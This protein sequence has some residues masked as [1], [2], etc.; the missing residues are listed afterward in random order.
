MKGI[1]KVLKI[2]GNLLLVAGLLAAG[3]VGMGGMIVTAPKPETKVPEVLPPQVRT[4]SVVTES[5]T[6]TIRAEGTVTPRTEGILVSEVSGRVIEVAPAFAPGGFFEEGAVLVKID[7][8]DFELAAV[9]ARAKVAAAESQLA[10]VEAE[11]KVAAAEWESLGEGKATPLVLRKPQLARARAEREA[12]RAALEHAEIKLE[13]TVIRAPYAGC[14][15]E[16]KTDVGQYMTVGSPIARVFAVD[17]AEIRLPLSDEQFA[18]LDVDVLQGRG[19]STGEGPEV[20]VHARVGG[21]DRTWT[22]RLVRIEGHVDPKS[23]M[24]YAVARVDDPY[25]RF[26]KAPHPPLAV[27]QFVRGE[28]KGR[29]VE[30]ALVISRF[31]IRDGDR[32]VVVDESNRLRFRTVEIVQLQGEKAVVRGLSDGESICLSA[33]EVAT[34]GMKVRTFEGETTG[35]LPVVN[36]EVKK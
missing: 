34:E 27:G 14:V 18:L 20:A 1:N 4:A 31:A 15:R 22:G 5:V 12:A 2:A 30:E 6:L 28:I 33:P 26:R 21:T 3:V 7:P 32:V 23:R 17:Y 36:S 9:Q 13:R 25:G 11:A 8:R 10:R 35:M 19:A 16:K 29:E 24:T